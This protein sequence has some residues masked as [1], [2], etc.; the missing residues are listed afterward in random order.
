MRVEHEILVHAPRETVWAVTVDVLR[1]PEWTPTVRS[2]RALDEGP[3]GIG[4]RFALKQP[5]QPETIWEVTAC[6]SGESFT[7]ETRGAKQLMRATHRLEAHEQGTRNTLVLEAPGIAGRLRQAIARFFIA[8]ALAKENAGL[9]A[10]Q[11]PGRSSPAP[12]LRC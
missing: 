4:R 1:W 6:T 2:A 8:K 11:G 5:F 10:S 3:F 9:G 7:W 12:A